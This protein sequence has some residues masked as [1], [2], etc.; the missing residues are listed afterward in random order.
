MKK[1]VIKIFLLCMIAAILMSGCGLGF[2]KT[3][4]A[5]GLYKKPKQDDITRAISEAVG[6]KLSYYSGEVNNEEKHII[7]NYQICD[8][9]D[10]EVLAKLVDAVNEELKNQKE[11][12]NVD[13]YICAEIPGGH[14][15]AVVLYNYYKIKTEKK[16]ESE[17]C[18]ITIRGLELA[19]EADASCYN[20]L[21]TYTSLE[22]MKHL[23]VKRDFAVQA[24]EEGID[25]HKV[26]PELE[27]YEEF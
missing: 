3:L 25:L 20:K 4:R 23:E 11:L 24:K 8:Y 26:W 1:N 10:P 13:I 21:F 27:Y 9:D 22:G 6:E 15:V 5:L 2:I 16:T 18:G 12:W 7:Y 19:D 14:E 17:I